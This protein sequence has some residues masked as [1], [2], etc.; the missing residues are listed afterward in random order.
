MFRKD[1]LHLNP[2][3]MSVNLSCL[4]RFPF[5]GVQ[6]KT[7]AGWGGGGVIQESAAPKGTVIQMFWSDIGYR[8][9]LFWYEGLKTGMNF[10]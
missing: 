8:F 10:T 2:V 3:K 5:S 1:H 7:R 6:S 9:Q 4:H